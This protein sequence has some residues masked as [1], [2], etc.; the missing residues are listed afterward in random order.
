[1]QTLMDLFNSV[2]EIIESSGKKIKRPKGPWPTPLLDPPTDSLKLERYPVSA[3]YE[4]SVQAVEQSGF[5][6][7]AAI[8]R[9]ATDLLTWSQNKSYT[10]DNLGEHFMDNYVLGQLTG[11][12]GPM[13]E[14]APPS[15]FLLMAENTLYPAHYHDPDEVYLVLTPG[16]EWCLDNK[17]WMPVSPGTV[18]YHAPNQ[19]HAIR[20]GST[21]MLAFAAW[22]IQGGRSA[23]HF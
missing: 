12:G 19:S 18:I 16:I 21:P 11:I 5:E 1:M 13:A 10:V 6:H 17:E 22:L 23:I 2:W 9:D 3:C 20:T 14:T 7:L 8:I 4:K 15:G